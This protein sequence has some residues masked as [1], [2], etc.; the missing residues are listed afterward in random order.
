[1]ISQ[2]RGLGDVY[3]RQDGLWWIGNYPNRH[4]TK[5]IYFTKR[6]EVGEDFFI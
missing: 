5:K 6:V 3:K 4:R 1:L 2:S